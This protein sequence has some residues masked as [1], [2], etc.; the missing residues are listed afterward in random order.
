MAVSVSVANEARERP[1]SLS[2]V[3]AGELGAGSPP[4]PRRRGAGGPRVRSPSGR[5][6]WPRSGPLQARGPAAR[7][8]GRRRR[9]TGTRPTFA[10]RSRTAGIP[11]V[12][13]VKG[14]DHRSWRSGPGALAAEVGAAAVGAG[15]RI[16][17]RRTP[18]HRP[19]KPQEPRRRELP[20]AAW[21]AGH[22][23]R[24]HARAPM[25]SRFARVRVRPAHRRCSNGRSL[26]R[27]KSAPDRVAAG[28]TRAHQVLAGDPARDACPSAE[29]VRLAKLPLAHRARLS[30]AQG[31]ARAGPLRGPRVARLSSP[32]RLMYRGV[33][34]PRG[35]AREV[36]PRRLWPSSDPLAFPKG[37]KPRGAPGAA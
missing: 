4:A 15:R 8:R 3:P 21:H 1:G 27:R 24:G 17:V 29:L 20:A 35:R 5:S 13:G 11:Y 26:G 18:R 12:V 6:P 14:D 19:V 23:A 36:F 25:R 30:G 2:P 33:C 37:F 22:L 10:R 28:G 7:A 32:W 31:R 16:R 34:L 9:A